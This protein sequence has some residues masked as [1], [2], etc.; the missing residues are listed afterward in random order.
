ML[1]TKD[2][3]HM[4]VVAKSHVPCQYCGSA[5]HQ[6][7]TCPQAEVCPTCKTKNQSLKYICPILKKLKNQD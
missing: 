3:F 4:I 6:S 2:L 7:C 5:D 1:V